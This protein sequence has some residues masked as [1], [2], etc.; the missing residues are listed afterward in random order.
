MRRT[1][2]LLLFIC[3]PLIIHAQVDL[4]LNGSVTWIDST[5]IRVIYDWSN[6]NQLSDWSTTNGSSLVRTN[7]F[8][9][10]TG[11]VVTVRAM[12]W[13]QGI[14]CSRITAENTTPL[15]SAGHLNFYSNVSSF[16]GSTYYPIRVLG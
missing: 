15:T 13:K 4:G 8:V 5:H 9:T 3:I 2:I 12:I 1:L 10:I 16:T 6:D 7:G 14:K 11:G